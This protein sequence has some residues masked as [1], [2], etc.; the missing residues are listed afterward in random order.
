MCTPWIYS[1][2]ALFFGSQNMRSLGHWQLRL[3]KPHAGWI[4]P[5]HCPAAQKVQWGMKKFIYIT[6]FKTM[7]FIIM[8]DLEKDGFNPSTLSGARVLSAQDSIV[9]PIV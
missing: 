5:N 8:F 4:K 9:V 6:Y 2:H 1:C 3:G 7:P